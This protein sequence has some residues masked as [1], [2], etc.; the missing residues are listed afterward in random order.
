MKE[1]DRAIT[2]LINLK[3]TKE[4]VEKQLAESEK[5]RARLAKENE[6][7]IELSVNSIL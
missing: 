7:N 1:R 3:K 5:E 4:D 2:E 6:G